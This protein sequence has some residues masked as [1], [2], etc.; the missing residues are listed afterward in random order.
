MPSHEAFRELSFEPEQLFDLAAN[1]ERYPEFLPGWVAARVRKRE[2]NVYYTDQIVG[3]GM[4]RER[5]A[6]MTVLQRPERIDVTSTDRLF[7]D[8]RLTW[9]FDPLP[10]S[11]CRVALS[12]ELELLVALVLDGNHALVVGETS[13]DQL[14][15]QTHI[16]QHHLDD[17]APHQ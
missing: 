12:V 14:A 17:V 5:F 9:H 4:V 1:V 7:R 2:A 6:S 10:V 3:F 15:R 13:I 8:F 11:G 16:R